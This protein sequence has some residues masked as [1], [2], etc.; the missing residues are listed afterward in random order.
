MRS[1]SIR[2]KPLNPALALPSALALL[3]IL[4]TL[5][6][7][8]V[9]A[10]I[11]SPTV[12][13]S[14]QG[15]PNDIFDPTGL[16]AQ[17]RDGNI[18]GTGPLEAANHQ[19]GIYKITPEGVETLIVSFP[20]NWQGCQGLSLG[21]DGNFYGT[22]GFDGAH[23]E[24]FVF[25]ATPAGVLTDIYDFT[26]DNNDGTPVTVPVLG[27]NGDFYGTSGRVNYACG[28]IYR[29]TT[30]GAYKNIKS[31]DA[32]CSPTQISAGSNGD[33]YGA[34]GNVPSGNT[35]AVFQVTASGT[36][37]EILDFNSTSD[38]SWYPITGPILANDG[39]LYG[40]D[41]GGGTDSYGAIYSL[42]TNGTAL[43]DLFNI[44]SSADGALEGNNL[45]QA[46]DGNFYGASY[47]G[48]SGNQG[49]FYE[50]T[51][52]NAFSVDLLVNNTTTGVGVGPSTALMQHTNGILYGTTSSNGPSGLGAFL[53]F[54]IGASP[55]VALVGP[56]PAA[57]EGTQVQILGQN[58]SSSS[59][60]KF[61]GTAATT[62]TV[63][64]TTF[65]ET[66]VPT[67]ALTGPIT[68][69]TSS[70]TLSTL[71]T[72]DVTPTAASFTPTSGDAGT[73]VTI[74]GTGLTQTTEVKFHGT[75]ATSFTVVSDS[76]ITAT[77]PTGA[78][79]GTVSVTTKGGTATSTAKFTV[80]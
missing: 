44:N 25:Q 73:V 67:G 29:V 14:F 45:I 35:G 22:C 8:V 60:V 37:K 47:N 6:S 5:T 72:F 56:V 54:D 30:A 12:L 70:G 49:S 71:V 51:S 55:F 43:T 21:F 65:I 16:L 17:G 32:Y 38:P 11:P 41:I 24:G 42:K 77:V 13:Y 33:F 18:Y 20:S 28:N 23:N 78:T 66:T 52:D 58:F 61:G 10:Q 75:K 59:E 2:H 48:G 3:T 53:S 26:D 63:T 15:V 7:T 57:T 76:E 62:V 79:T 31:G 36:Y 50:L 80:N 68:V 46:S 4:F 64:G 27:A 39:K 40:T 69:T 9:Q 34:W 19:G 74:N 1:I